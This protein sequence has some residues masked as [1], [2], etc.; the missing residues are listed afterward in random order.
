MLVMVSLNDVN[1]DDQD[2]DD[3][4]VRGCSVAWCTVVCV[5]VCVCGR[6]GIGQIGL[7]MSSLLP[8]ADNFKVIQDSVIRGMILINPIG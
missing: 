2:W 5:C 6:S 3:E 4:V 1:T 8:C 7:S